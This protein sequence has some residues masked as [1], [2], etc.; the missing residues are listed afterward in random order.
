MAVFGEDVST[1]SVT[2]DTTSIP[3]NTDLN[4]NDAADTNSEC[5][6]LKHKKFRKRSF[7][8]SASSVSDCCNNSKFC[9]ID[10]S[11]EDDASGKKLKNLPIKKRRKFLN[12]RDD[13]SHSGESRRINEDELLPNDTKNVG[14]EQRLPEPKSHEGL[15]KT[16]CAAKSSTSQFSMS[17]SNN[18]KG[19]R[20]FTARG[21]RYKNP[22]LETSEKRTLLPY[23]PTELLH[24]QG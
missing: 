2:D 24:R 7:V 6:S 17:Y 12:N 15:T 13:A 8:S 3:A 23:V 19:W 10:H 20:G 21:K 22:R 18:N 16:H 14:Y 11:V 1:E 5:Y 4:N 9:E